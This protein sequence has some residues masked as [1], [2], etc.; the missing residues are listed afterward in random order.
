MPRDKF[1]MVFPLSSNVVGCAGI[2]VWSIAATPTLQFRDLCNVEATDFARRGFNNHQ[3][4]K[5]RGHKT[6]TIAQAYVNLVSQDMNDV[7]DRTEATSPVLQV[8]PPA[9]RWR[10][11]ASA[12]CRCRPW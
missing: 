3:L 10:F 9:R 8:P 2:R 11:H 6:I 7:T 5:V 12:N 1:G 4:M